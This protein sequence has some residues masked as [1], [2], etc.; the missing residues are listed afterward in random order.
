MSPWI[1]SLAE[2]TGPTMDVTDI[3]RDGSPDSVPDVVGAGLLAD[4]FGAAPP[5]LTQSEFVSIGEAVEALL[6]SGDENISTAIATGFLESLL[7]QASGGTLDF[8]RIAWALGPESK[9]HCRAW[10]DFSGLKTEGLWG[11]ASGQ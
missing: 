9:E 8:S 7:G 5:V 6:T 4:A 3:E 10:D 1:R 2:L 11:A